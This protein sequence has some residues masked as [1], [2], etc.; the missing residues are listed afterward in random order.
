MARIRDALDGDFEDVVREAR[1]LS[2]WHYYLRRYPL[3]SVA[4]SFSLGYLLVPR[5]LEIQAPSEKTLEKLARKHR[6]VIQ[7]RPAVEAPSG[8]LSGA[9]NF[10]FRLALSGGLTYLGQYLGRIFDRSGTEEDS[11]TKTAAAAGPAVSRSGDRRA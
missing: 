4:A 5:R 6:L 3:L 2:T 11:A 10:L 8:L 1:T 7:P 9:F